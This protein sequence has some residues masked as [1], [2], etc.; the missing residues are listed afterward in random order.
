MIKSKDVIGMAV[1]FA[2]LCVLVA[3]AEMIWE[4]PKTFTMSSKIGISDTYNGTDYIKY[5]EQ[6]YICNLT[7]KDG[8]DC[9]FTYT[10]IME[11]NGAVVGFLRQKSH[12]HDTQIIVLDLR[13]K[14]F[15]KTFEQGDLRVTIFGDCNDI[16]DKNADHQ[17]KLKEDAVSLLIPGTFVP[18][19]A[20]Y[21]AR[22]VGRDED[23]IAAATLWNE[24]HK[25]FLQ[26]VIHVIQTEGG[27]TDR[28]KSAIDK[29]AF[30]MVER[31]VGGSGDTASYCRGA[32][33]IINSGQLDLDK[34]EQTRATLGRVMGE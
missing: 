20:A 8:D 26:Q 12:P 27:L 31:E 18:G 15:Y 6:Q 4:C 28:E 34:M 13:N 14:R 23:L 17:W 33:E 22:H 3:N 9:Y 2:T 11:R 21:C 10:N 30:V 29:L 24:R 7:D 16:N 19:I 25:I 5:V 1:L 32:T